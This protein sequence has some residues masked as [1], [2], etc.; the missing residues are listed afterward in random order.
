MTYCWRT[1][2]LT[3]ALLGVAAA[4]SLAQSAPNPACGLLT[5]ADLQKITGKSYGE[6]D[7]GDAMG[8]GA[9]GGASC[10]W[11]EPGSRGPAMISVVYI[12]AKGGKGYTEIN[13]GRN[14]RPGCQRDPVSAL[15]DAAY[16]ESCPKDRG[17]AVYIK[18]GA[19]DLIVQMDANPPGSSASIKPTLIAV[20]KAAVANAR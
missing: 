9:G 8:E 13:R 2:L 6:G 11:G 15:G 18:V 17:P 4:T 20:A 12:P 7:E 3:M 19:N 1:M 16:I 14:L 10:Q 5:A